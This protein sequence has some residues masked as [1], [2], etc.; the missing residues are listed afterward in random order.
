MPDFKAKPTVYDGVRFRSKSEAIFAVA[1][2]TDNP[3]TTWEYEPQLFGFNFL[4]DFLLLGRCKGRITGVLI[5]YKPRMPSDFYIENCAV[6]Y[7]KFLSGGG[8]L[9]DK[10]DAF[11]IV[12]GSPFGDDKTLTSIN[13]D[14]LVGKRCG[15]DLTNYMQ[16][17]FE[18]AASYRFD[19]EQG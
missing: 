13:I 17:R 6:C 14:E 11:S 10:C 16:T 7:E 12:Y 18:V 3:N 15:F 4:V 9:A 8:W 2:S 1:L 5:E 19:L